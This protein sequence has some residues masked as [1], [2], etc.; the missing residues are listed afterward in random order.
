MSLVR[1]NVPQSPSTLNLKDPS[2]QTMPPFDWLK[3]NVFAKKYFEA[4]ICLFFAALTLVMAPLPFMIGI[5]IGFLGQYGLNKFRSKKQIKKDPVIEG[6]EKTLR[7]VQKI[8]YP[9]EDK[10]HAPKNALGLEKETDK[11]KKIKTGD[12][13]ILG[14][15]VLASSGI[16]LLPKVLSYA[17]AFGAG[18]G[19]GC[20]LFREFNNLMEK[21]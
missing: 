12:S 8:E 15:Q 16:F 7:A 4:T 3:I 2:V 17:C 18:A 1:Q 13:A 19:V 14:F 21:K 11:K 10:H 20:L 9:L 5:P 6:F